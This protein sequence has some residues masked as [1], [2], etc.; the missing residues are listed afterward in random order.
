MDEPSVLDYLKSLLTP[1]KGKPIPFPAE[2]P[3]AGSADPDM[4]DSVDTAIEVPAELVVE[5]AEPITDRA[6]ESHLPEE[7]ET[8]VGAPDSGESIKTEPTMPA[9]GKPKSSWPWRT[10][11]AIPLALAGQYALSPVFHAGLLGGILLIQAAI[12]FIWGMV[13]GEW[14]DDDRKAEEIQTDT[15]RVRPVSFA[16]GLILAFLA[17]LASSEGQFT[18]LNISFLGASLAFL[19]HAFWQGEF[20]FLSRSRDLYQ[21]ATRSEWRLHITRWHLLVLAAVILVLFFRLYHLD[22]TPPEMVSDHAEKFL[23]VDSILNGDTWIFFPRNGGREAL[24]F[25]LLAALVKYFG[26]PVSHLTLKISTTLIGL[27]ALPYVY[28]LGKEVANRR[29]ALI[30]FTFAG[31]A[32]WTNVVS[33]AGMRLPFYFLFSAAILYHLVRGIRSANRNQF[34]FAGFF[35]GLGFYGYS[36]DRLLPLVVLAAIGLFLLHRQASGLRKPILIY[37]ILLLLIAL[38]VFLPLLR[39]IILDPAGF[40]QRMFSRMSGSEQPLS[41]PAIIIFFSNLWNALRMFSISAGVVWGVSVPNYPA[42]GVVAGGLFYLGIAL[43]LYRYY[44]QRNWLYLFLLISIPL[45]M[46]PSILSL[47]FPDENPNLYRTGGAMVPV[48][49]LVGLALDGVMSAVEKSLGKR[50]GSR[51]AWLLM[52][53]LVFFA[54]RQEYTLV[55]RDFQDNYRLSAWNYREMGQA[56]RDFGA[57]FGSPETTWIMGY[58]HWADTRLVAINAGNP[59]RDLAMFVERLPETLTDPRAKLFIVHP[60]DQAGLEALFQF[61]PRGWVQTYYSSVPTK[62]FLIFFAPPAE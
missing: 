6:V 5:T 59:T 40:S 21:R 46:L 14:A 1:W 8:Q 28:L 42:L 29:V 43:A 54:A 33:R 35:L 61:Y 47:A 52:L 11:I 39:Y 58:P 13:K 25:Y 17:F 62:D 27:L 20:D 48:F 57:T 22:Q 10:L 53:T 24:Q 37:T 19:L 9:P 23:D 16:I 15:M 44:K 38:V 34:I 60:L 41:N 7:D 12:F 49:L 55:F 56:V 36:A 4:P 31:F 3:S 51:L 26:Q 30:A 50:Q 2:D 32:Y 18:A 45:L